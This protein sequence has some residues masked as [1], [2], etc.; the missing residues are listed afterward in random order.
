MVPYQKAKA[1]D[2]YIRKK[3]IPIEILAE[4]AFLIPMRLASSNFFWYL[5]EK[6]QK[7]RKYRE[8]IVLSLC[9]F[10]IFP[11]NT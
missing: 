2:A 1:Y 8:L 11:L 7:N 5:K 3:A 10:V 6:K 9:I 4:I